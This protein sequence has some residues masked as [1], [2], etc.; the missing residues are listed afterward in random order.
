MLQ[1]RNKEL[2]QVGSLPPCLNHNIWEKHG[3][4][5]KSMEAQTNSADIFLKFVTPS[6][7]I[8]FQLSK[9]LYFNI[10]HV[11]THLHMGYDFAAGVLFKIT[12]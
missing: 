8:D 7:L 1:P 2:R 11:C 6:N 5:E 12:M 9:N 10:S 3:R 4:H